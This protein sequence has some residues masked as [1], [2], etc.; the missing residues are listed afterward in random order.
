MNTFMNDD[1]L[2]TNKTARRL[3][4]EV[5]KGQPICDYHCHLSAKEIYEN[6]PATDIGALWLTQDH[7]KWRLMRAGGVPEQMITGNAPLAVKFE[8]YAGALEQAIGNP[9][10][11]WSHLELKRYFN[12]DTPISRASANDIYTRANE[13]MRNGSFTPR[14]LIRCSNVTAICTTDD[15]LDD[16]SYHRLLSELIDFPVRVLPTFRPD[17]AI[18]IHKPGFAGYLDQLAAVSGAPIDSIPALKQALCKR[19]D[20][21]ADCG[22]RMSDHGLDRLVFRHASEDSLNDIFSRAR[23]GGSVTA[24]EAEAYI[25][26]MLLFLAGEYRRRNIVMQL[27]F[28]CL[29]N[30]SETMFARLGADSG[31]DSTDDAGNA[32]ALARLL[33]AMERATAMPAT[34][35]YP[36]NPNDNEAVLAVMGAFQTDGARMNFGSAWWFADH[37]EGLTKQLKDLSALGVLGRFLG[38]LTD[39][40]SILSYTRHEYFRRVLCNLLGCWVENGEYPND[41]ALL[42]QLVRNICYENIQRLLNI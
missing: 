28:G 14:T 21:F 38:M 29:R 31:F 20:W 39:S 8:A 15:P 5:A 25:T 16:L 4:H 6:Q 2:L 37:Y 32:N 41:P 1:F 23:S 30:P 18:N 11:A 22:C 12:I 17:R 40:R 42:D 10:Y 24:I 13:I 35:L 3:F 36:L 34:I 26:H 9:L 33:S 27:H 19:L 7:Y